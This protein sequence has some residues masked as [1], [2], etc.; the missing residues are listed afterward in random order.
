[1]LFLFLHRI[2][3][4]DSMH[5]I[6]YNRDAAVEYGEKWALTRNPSYYNFDGLGGDCTNF[7]SQCIYAGSK[8]MNYQSVNGWFYRSSADRT[9]SWTSVEY[10][11][12]FLMNNKSVG[13][14][15]S[16][17]GSDHLLVGDVVQLGNGNGRYYHSLLV[18]QTYPQ[19]LVA[20]HTDDAL[21]RPL[22]SYDYKS[23]RF[24]HVDGV[25]TW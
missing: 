21:N 1:M 13:P 7:V 5:I 6:T 18:T 3:R 8:V 24:L 23:L 14:F 11:F 15:G 20:A 2:C 10:L 22:S 19:I 16:V 9:A 17:V 25:R 4:G 12:S